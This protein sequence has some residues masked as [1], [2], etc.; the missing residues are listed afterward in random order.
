VQRSVLIVG[1][2]IGG[3][4]AAIAMRRQGF[5][6]QIVER[7]PQWS[8]Y[9]VGIIQQMNVVRA[10]QQIG[11]LDAYLSRAHGFD[12][13][14]IFVGPAGVKETSFETPRLAG[15]GYPSNAGIRRTD[16]Q[17]VLGRCGACGGDHHPA[18]R[19]GRRDD[20]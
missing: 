16:L 4:T 3:L 20:R 8:V 5:A 9:G 6:V 2:G 1:G 7:D 12:R 14:T 15:P 18:G 13:T 11:V 17:V 19:D 10:M